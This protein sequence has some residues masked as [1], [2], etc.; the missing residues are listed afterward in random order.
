[1]GAPLPGVTP[2]SIKG[3]LLFV[4]A[5]IGIILT[6]LAGYL[7]WNVRQISVQAAIARDGTGFLREIS[8]I[9]LRLYRQMHA[10][11]R[12]H[13][14]N[15]EDA[16]GDCEALGRE[17]S[18]AFLRLRES[19]RVRSGSLHGTGAAGQESRDIIN[20]RS[21]E[22]SYRDMIIIIDQSFSQKKAGDSSGARRLIN[23]RGEPLLDD[24]LLREMSKAIADKADDMLAAY[25]E[26][27]MR[28]GAMPWAVE[29]NRRRLQ[30][31]RLSLQYYLAVDKLSLQLNHQ[32]NE[33]A[34]YI[35][36]SHQ[37]N[38]REFT[39][40]GAEVEEAFEESRKIIEAQIGLGMEGEK[41]QLQEVN[42]LLR[43]YQ[44]VKAIFNRAFGLKHAGRADAAFAVMD[45]TIKPRGIRHLLPKIESIMDQNRN[46]ILSAHVFLLKSI[47]LSG[48]L[49]ITSV[50]IVA[51]LLIA[52]T[53]R[54]IRHMVVAVERLSIGADRVGRGNLDH[55]IKVESSDELGRLASSFNRMTASL[56]DSNEDLRAFIYSLSHDLRS[57]LVNIKGFSSE[58]AQVLKES[59]DLLDRA[60]GALP[61]ADGRRLQAILQNEIPAALEFLGG[62]AERINELVNS[63]LKLSQVGQRELKPEP[64]DMA[65]LVR[66]SLERHAE[67]IKQRNITVNIADLPGLAADRSAMQEI[68]DHLIDNAVKYLS[69]DRP[70]FI[71]VTGRR[72][73]GETLFHIRDNGRGIA[74]GDLA[75]IFGLFR[76][77]GEQDTPGK[78]MGLTYVKALIRLQSGRIWCESEAGSGTLFTFSLPDSM[79][80][81]R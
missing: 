32:L 46:E 66:S 56:R 61:E 81:G 38:L 41:N 26:I 55:T 13:F 43:E 12:Y 2:L 64:L 27:S 67:E 63:V 70:G 24:V 78:G 72:N 23:D 39:E 77:V 8:D 14:F 59:D 51:L 9:R 3:K 73:G 18:A 6:S 65:A 49:S 29:K 7:I 37:R 1:M 48:V 50:A 21:L 80:P 22:N 58:L 5:V 15:E 71:E 31:I 62:A 36:T 33:A 42:S 30:G 76:R 16:K 4:L 10:L 44:E 11:T 40:S 54:V 52:G 69:P 53:Y 47:Y 20:T 17:L 75:K 28:I 68:I 25:E 19:L 60:A 34:A 35:V 79:K 45:E 57:P 74:T